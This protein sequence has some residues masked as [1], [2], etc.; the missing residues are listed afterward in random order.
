MRRFSIVPLVLALALP[1]ALR[2]DPVNGFG[3]TL[4]GVTA[5]Q[6]GLTSSGVSLGG[7]AQFVLDGAWS[8]N[9]CLMVSLERASATGQNVS[10]NLGGIQF[11]RWLGPVYFGPQVFFHDRLLYGSGTVSSSQYGPGL[12]LVLGWEGAAGWSTG[13]QVDALEG[14]FLNPGDRRNALRVYAGYRWH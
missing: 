3:V 4:G 12:G 9:P 13:V 8:I 10:D 6:G 14:Q 7:D 11:R 2:A 1:Q 5:S